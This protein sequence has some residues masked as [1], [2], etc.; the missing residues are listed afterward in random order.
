[1]I[2][3]QIN[4]RYEKVLL[5]DDDKV[6]RFISEKIIKTSGFAQTVIMKSCASTALEYLKEHED[7]AHALPEIIFL[8]YEMP[9]MTGIDFLRA[10]QQLNQSVV[11]RCKIFMLTNFPDSRELGNA[12][13]MENLHV[14]G[15][16]DKPLNAESLLKIEL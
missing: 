10:F 7:K 12:I 1:M 13:E 4:A 9:A 8:D 5:I 16:L 15:I 11:T 14:N 3:N 6:D 2:K